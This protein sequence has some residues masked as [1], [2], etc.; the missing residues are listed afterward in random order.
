MTDKEKLDIFDLLKRVDSG[1]VTFYD[2][3]D[4]NLQKQFAPVVACRWMAGTQ[5]PVQI[6]LVN[7]FVNRYVFALHQH[8]GLLY[9][10]MVVASDGSA[11]PYHWMKKKTKGGTRPVSAE[12]IEARLECSEREAIDYSKLLDE[13]T[14][15]SYVQE[16]G[17]DDAYIKKVQAEFK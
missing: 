11:K 5:S 15:L 10:M 12:I 1:D 9:R 13:A 6:K 4:P 8:K 14:V 16:L 3:L 17:Y 2:N 7:E